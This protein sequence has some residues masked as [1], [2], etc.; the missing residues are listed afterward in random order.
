MINCCLISKKIILAKH[1]RGRGTRYA[2][3]H[4]FRVFLGAR[5]VQDRHGQRATAAAYDT[6]N[7]RSG[8]VA[9]PTKDPAVGGK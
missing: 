6:V 8:R 7:V 3:P 2:W 1:P 4:F 5:I 9:V